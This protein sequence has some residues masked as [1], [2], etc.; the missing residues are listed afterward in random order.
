MRVWLRPARPTVGLLL[1]LFILTAC[2]VPASMRVR[3]G[4]D[5]RHQDKDVRFRTTYY[6]RVF[7]V[8]E[9]SHDD[10]D[11]RPRT[12]TVL[13]GKRGG[14]Y[15]LKT[16]SLYRFRMTGKGYSFFQRIHFE[17][18]TLRKEEI[19]PFGSNVVLDE[20]SNR[21]VYKSRQ[22]AE[23]EARRDARFLDIER[24][25]D[26]KQKF[27][28]GDTAAREEIDR[29]IDA[30]IR[31]LGPLVTGERERRGR[32]ASLGIWEGLAP[33]IAAL[34]GQVDS[35]VKALEEEKAS[36]EKFAEP[37]P[38][39]K[40][41]KEAVADLTDAT[42]ALKKFVDAKDTRQ[43][44]LKKVQ[45]EATAVVTRSE[46][47]RKALEGKDK[48]T[49]DDV[50]VAE[51]YGTRAAGYYGVAAAM[52][53]AMTSGREDL[54]AGL[55]AATRAAGRLTEFSKST[56]AADDAPINVRARALGGIVERLQNDVSGWRDLSDAVAR[57]ARSA[58]DVG[59]LGAARR[60]SESSA[61]ARPTA[62]ASRI[63]CADGTPARRGFQ[64]LGPEGFRT[65][66]QDERLIMAM[67]SSAKPLIQTLQE[68]SR[69]V[70]ASQPN[71]ADT[72]LPLVLERLR[73][74]ETT[75]KVERYQESGAGTVADLV[76][77][78]LA[79]FDRGTSEPEKK[80]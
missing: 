1:G 39:V 35:I 25:R 31:A 23:S 12:D 61:A 74:V 36:L 29:L 73:I 40:A 43:S 59:G 33:R 26:L 48:P 7:D 10:Q 34:D 21:F 18:G 58:S 27:D 41:A 67:S 24:L 45:E 13:G 2:S 55:T 54:N 76:K 11:A 68:I 77:D 19:E 46:S 22:E 8:C 20:R 38:G 70:L 56:R 4:V 49:E 6:F 32:A 71:P 64:I 62:V 5:P 79:T 69:N 78:I 44:A 42:Q 47:A 16:D 65:F 15:H 60:G 53:A 3:S 75:H 28:P 37:T 9:G 14:P 66:D 50:K 17:S 63:L 57:G 72:L 80:P 52:G 51:G 30:Q